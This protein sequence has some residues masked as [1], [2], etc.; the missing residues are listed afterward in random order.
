[1]RAG[2]QTPAHARWTRS[3]KNRLNRSKRI[4][5]RSCDRTCKGVCDVD[6]SSPCGAQQDSHD[7]LPSVLGHAIV[8]IDSGEENERVDDDLKLVMF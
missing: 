8:V 6:A 3:P 1:M 7:A 4:A 2:I 5:T